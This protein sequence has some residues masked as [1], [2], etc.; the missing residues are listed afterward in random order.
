MNVPEYYNNDIEKANTHPLLPPK[1][2]EAPKPNS[3]SGQS[4]TPNRRGNVLGGT[5]GRRSVGPFPGRPTMTKTK[6]TTLV[7]N[8]NRI[9]WADTV[10]RKPI[11]QQSIQEPTRDGFLGTI[12][13]FATRLNRL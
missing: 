10:S 5:A 3:T 6:T 8:T 2:T 1:A 9:L 13:Q 12:E 4:T 7:T 11:Q